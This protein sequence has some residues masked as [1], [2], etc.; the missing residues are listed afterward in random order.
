MAATDGMKTMPWIKWLDLDTDL[1]NDTVRSSLRRPKA[2]HLNHN[3]H[4]NAAVA[5]G[6]AE[7]AG[8]G[9]VVRA[10]G[11]RGPGAYTVIKTGTIDYRRPTADGITATATLTTAAADRLSQ[12]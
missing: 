12:A 11:S 1:S 5:Y 4:I 3:G 9:A 2:E 6:G 8:A 10:T 7:V